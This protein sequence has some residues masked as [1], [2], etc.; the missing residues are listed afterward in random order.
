MFS[1]EFFAESSDS[2]QSVTAIPVMGEDH[3]V[4]E[5]QV[6]LSDGWIDRAVRAGK[7]AGFEVVLNFFGHVLIPS[8]LGLHST[9]RHW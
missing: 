6:F 2:E 4:S 8:L 5:N 3:A 1:E 9:A 7:K